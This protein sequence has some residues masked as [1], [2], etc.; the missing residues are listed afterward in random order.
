VAGAAEARANQRE[1]IKNSER[2]AEASEQELTQWPVDE[3][4]DPMVRISMQ[5]MELVGLKEFS[6][7]TVG[8]ARAET[9]VSRNTKNPF[10]E[11][12]L[13]NIASA[14]NQLAELVEVDVVAEQ[15]EV[16]LNTIDPAKRHD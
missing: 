11:A 4:G 15:R 13:K 2:A 1:A 7:I 6:N 9:F 8:P 14:M 12:Q 3:H 16:A 10:S 5:A